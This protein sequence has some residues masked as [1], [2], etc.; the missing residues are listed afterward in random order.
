MNDDRRGVR[1][2]VRTALDDGALRGTLGRIRHQ[3]TARIVALV[4][5]SLVGLLLVWVHWI[6]LIIAGALVGV[7]SP[8]L[9]AALGSA[10][11]FGLLVLGVFFLSR[12]AIAPRVV[13]MDPIIYVTVAGA[14]V[15]PVLG[16]LVR[17]T[18]S[19]S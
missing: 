9:R 19:S 14:L 15:L 2:E 17:G 3:R 11:G 6:G 1:E 5:T 10:V 7:V 13:S 12:G 16:A 18:E 4:A 8:G